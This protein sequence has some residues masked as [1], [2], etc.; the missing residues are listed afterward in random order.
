MAITKLSNSGILTTGNLKYD[1]MLAGNDG[2]RIFQ[3]VSLPTNWT[4]ANVL[5]FINS[6][7]IIGGTQSGIGAIATSTN[8]QSWTNKAQTNGGTTWT[9]SIAGSPSLYVMSDEN[10]QS[11]SGTDLMTW[12]NRTK[13]VSGSLQGGQIWDNTNSKFIQAGSKSTGSF[14]IAYSSDGITW[15]GVSA[16]SAAFNCLATNAG[17]TVAAGNSGTLYYSTNATTWTAGT[18]NTATTLTG[19]AYGNGVWVAVGNAGTLISSTDGITWTVRT[20]SFGTSSISDVAYSNGTFMA[21]SS[22]T[23]KIATS[24]DGINWTQMSMYQQPFV[25]GDSFYYI[26]ANTTGLFT[27]YCSGSTSN[28]TA[29]IQL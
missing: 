22:S 28:F 26:A 8:G 23:N 6:Q 3:T 10:N 1:S 19:V 7:F 27:V 5:K 25:A 20:S 18:S 14:N 11:K 21:V 13:G 16:G 4:S 24:K 2:L 29:W 15:T 12:T 17:T 9:A